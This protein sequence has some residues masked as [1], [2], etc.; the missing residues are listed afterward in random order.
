MERVGIRELRQ[1]LSVYIA[2]VKGGAAFEV[3][4]RG[5]A[6]AVLKPAR[7]ED[8]V[9]RQLI[10]AGRLIPAQTSFFDLE[11]PGE[12]VDGARTVSRYLQEMREDRG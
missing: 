8:D 7:R 4:D 5:R 2:K 6:V 3:T 12:E 10:D 11:P 9:W 1:N